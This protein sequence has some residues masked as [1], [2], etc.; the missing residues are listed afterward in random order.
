MGLRLHLSPGT[1]GNAAAHLPR[2]VMGKWGVD[3]QAGRKS[4]GKPVCDSAT[5]GTGR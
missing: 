5:G 4:L 3:Y 2:G 1:V